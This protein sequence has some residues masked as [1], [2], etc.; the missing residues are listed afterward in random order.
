MIVSTGRLYRAFLCF[1]FSTRLAHCTS[2]IITGSGN[3]R[4]GF[5]I[6]SSGPTVSDAKNRSVGRKRSHQ[7]ITAQLVENYEQLDRRNPVDNWEDLIESTQ[8]P[9][10]KKKSLAKKEIKR[11]P[12]AIPSQLPTNSLLAGKQ[13]N[14]KYLLPKID[15]EIFLL[16]I[17]DQLEGTLKNHF[18]SQYNA[19]FT[20]WTLLNLCFSKRHPQLIKAMYVSVCINGV[21]MFCKFSAKQVDF[22]CEFGA[23]EVLKQTTLSTVYRPVAAFHTNV[24]LLPYAVVSQFID[25][26]N[27]FE[28]LVHCHSITFGQFA[29]VMRNFAL[30]IDSLHQYCLVH[31]DI[32]LENTIV[33][34]ET[35]S[36]YLIDFGHSC[37]LSSLTETMAGVWGTPYSAAP[38]TLRAKEEFTY[39]CDWYSFGACLFYG[40]LIFAN[41]FKDSVPYDVL[42]NNQTISKFIPDYNLRQLIR[43]LIQPESKRLASCQQVLA[44]P[45]FSNSE[46]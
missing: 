23:F 7:S 39:R 5:Y 22:A 24:P 33:N 9:P 35:L 45:F 26:P 37:L 15:S 46:A 14:W 19:A 21:K 3:S 16:Q 4:P 36:V 40:Y 12:F 1:C 25:Q 38:E 32:K 6:G 20:E 44:E 13:S 29:E 8:S 30:A 31:R 41:V 11:E 2:R 28:F 17:S 43:K 34:R 18:Q 27:M 10:S 42:L